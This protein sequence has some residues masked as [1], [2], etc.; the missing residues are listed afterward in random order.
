MTGSGA[1]LCGEFNISGHI[2]LVADLPFI[3]IINLQFGLKN[4]DPGHDPTGRRAR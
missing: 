4:I 1:P 3:Q 2:W